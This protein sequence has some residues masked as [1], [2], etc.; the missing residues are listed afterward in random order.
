MGARG[1]GVEYSAMSPM[2]PTNSPAS[3]NLAAKFGAGTCGTAGSLPRII[4]E[5]ATYPSRCCENEIRHFKLI[6]SNGA[7]GPVA[8]YNARLD[9]HSLNLPLRSAERVS[10]VHGITNDITVL[11]N[12]QQFSTLKVHRSGTK[13]YHE[14]RTLWLTQKG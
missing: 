8:P 14:R 10:A 3:T 2:A 12:T 7:G 1:R 6:G 4:S 13:A 11:T 9:V 5:T